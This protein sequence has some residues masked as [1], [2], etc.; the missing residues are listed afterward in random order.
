M[1]HAYLLILLTAAVVCLA[2]ANLFWGSLDIPASAVGRILM[3]GEAAE[4][5]SWTF[6]VLQSR[7]PQAITALLCG[8]SLSTCGLLL[9]TIF[10]N[11]L[12]GPSILGIDAGAN[13]GVALVMLLWAGAISI[14]SISASGY[15]L[16]VIAAMIGAMLI[17]F[18]LLTLSHILHNQ[19]MLLITGVIISYVT[20]SI[21]QLL[22]FSSTKEGVHSFVMWGMG[23]FS[24]VSI[25]RLPIFSALTFSGLLLSTL[26]IKPLDALLLGDH[27]AQN[28]GIRVKWTQRMLLLNTGILTATTTAFCGPI[29]FL[30]LAVPHISRMIL[31]TSSHRILLPGTMLMGALLTL[32]CNLISTV[33]HPNIIIPIN[34]ITPLIGAPVIL[35]V[36]LKSKH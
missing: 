33:S 4:H 36:I 7:V 9:Q 28:L 16:V 21:I 30:G 17:M 35:Y 1:K 24:S 27:Y 2:I 29:T 25:E 23:N 14:G 31:R 13:L 18:L 5:P 12:A 6:I 19:V 22:N 11:P 32:A 20:G 8:A 3:G 34:V 15:L 26:L 10:R